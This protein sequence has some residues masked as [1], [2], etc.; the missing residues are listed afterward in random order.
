MSSNRED[1]PS[2]DTQL[3]WKKGQS[4]F[5]NWGGGWEVDITH[6]YL[7]IGLPKGKVNFLLP[8]TGTFYKLEWDDFRSFYPPIRWKM[9][10]P[11]SLWLYFKTMAPRFLRKTVFGCNTSQ[12]TSKN[13]HISKGGE[14]NDKYSRVHTLR[15]GKSRIYRREEVSLKFKL[16][17]TLRPSWSTQNKYFLRHWDIFLKYLD[18]NVWM[19]ILQSRVLEQWAI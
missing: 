7:L 1:R 5:K 9:G 2:A 6:L 3:C 15:K 18:M 16:R 12:E 19:N 13:I 17:G 14:G 11:P 4:I 10:T 8:S